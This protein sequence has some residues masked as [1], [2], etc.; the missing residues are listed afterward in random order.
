MIDLYI[1]FFKETEKGTE[2]R[3][4]R[5]LLE[6]G[7]RERY[8]IEF[9]NGWLEEGVNGKPH[10]RPFPDIH[11]NISHTEGLAV[12]AFADTPVGVDTEKVK[13]VRDP[14]VR[15]VL[16][17][18][19]QDVLYRFRDSADMINGKEVSVFDDSEREREFDTVF[20]RYWT[21]KESYLKREG[22]GLTREPG[23]IRF[24]L[25]PGDWESPITCPGGQAVCMQRRIQKNDGNPDT[26]VL[27]VCTGMEDGKK[28]KG[29]RYHKLSVYGT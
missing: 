11:F 12:C 7:L 1:S 14:L 2:H 24:L 4:G 5:M 18:E 25:D 21:L 10:L 29:V 22:C 20:F 3:I 6:Y 8:G 15:R 28:E 26:Y 9:E 27:S 19:E 23:E 17:R 16:C 13:K